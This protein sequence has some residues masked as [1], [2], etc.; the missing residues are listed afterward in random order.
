M[1][2]LLASI[3]ALILHVLLGWQWSLGGGVVAGLMARRAGWAVGMTAV[4]LAWTAL[5]LY[6]F[7][8]A[9]AEIA[10]LLEI[11]SG[12]FGNIPPF[13]LVVITI[14]LG[15][16]LGL[17]GGIFGTLLRRLFTPVGPEVRVENPEPD[18]SI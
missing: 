8:A 3:L 14:L 7:A 15:A 6:N 16:L 4:A 17:L 2:L 18:T 13:S 1:P 11:A 10:R 12:I 9:P 5:V